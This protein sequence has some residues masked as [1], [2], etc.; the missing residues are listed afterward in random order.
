MVLGG[1]TWDSIQMFL[2][3]ETTMKQNKPME[4]VAFEVSGLIQV[5]D[6]NTGEMIRET[7]NAVHPQNMAR[8]IARALAHEDNHYIYRMAF[9]NGGTSVDASELITYY[10]PR[11]CQAP[12]PN[13]FNSTMYNQTYSEVIDD[14]SPLIGTG[15]GAVPSNDPPT[16]PYVSG[17]GCRSTEDGLVS[18]VVCECVLNASEPTS[19]YLTDMIGTPGYPESDFTFD[20][21]SLYTGGAPLASTAGYQDVNV[22]VKYASSETGLMPSLEYTFNLVVN[23]GSPVP[24]SFI[25]PAVGAGVG[26]NITYVDLIAVINPIL[27]AFGCYASISSESVITYGYLRFNSTLAGASSLVVV[28]NAGTRPLFTALG[29][30]VQIEA[31]VAGK[32]AGVQNAPSNPSTE[33]ERLL[34]HAIFSPIVKTANRSFTIRYVLT[35]SVARSRSPRLT[36]Q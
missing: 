16:V 29:G 26:G 12:D 15:P 10:P 8:V 23:G 24:I 32:D 9:G 35:I 20:E 30:F 6:T 28:T 33:V 4:P 13:S 14:Q 19:E 25:T 7:K 18:K 34:T 3:N 11:D 2:I 5:L 27:S 17:P 22:G 31:A 36:A 21:I 1:I